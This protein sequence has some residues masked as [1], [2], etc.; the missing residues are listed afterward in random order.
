MR[1][2]NIIIFQSSK[3]NRADTTRSNVPLVNIST[4]STIYF[5]MIITMG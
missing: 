4:S 5:N 3:Q 1:K 2:L